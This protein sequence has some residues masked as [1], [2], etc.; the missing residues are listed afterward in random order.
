MIGINHGGRGDQELKE[1][2]LLVQPSDLADS[3]K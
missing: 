1:G 2:V 3:G